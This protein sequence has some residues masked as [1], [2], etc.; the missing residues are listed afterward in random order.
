MP[1]Q[2]GRLRKGRE[3]DSAYREGTV[4]HGPL[5][6]LRVRLNEVG[7]PRWGFAVGKKLVPHAVGRNRLRRQLREAAKAAGVAAPCDFMV[8]A[9][10]RLLDASYAEMQTELSILVRRGAERVGRDAGT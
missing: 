1:A 4:L 9:K 2:L 3:F 8:T 6:V 7:R 5:F 10:A